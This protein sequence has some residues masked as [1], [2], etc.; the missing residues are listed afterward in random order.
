MYD[1]LVKPSRPIVNY[2]TKFSGITKEILQDVTTTLED[3]QKAMQNILPEDAILVGHSLNC[4]LEAMQ[5]S[6][7]SKLNYWLVG[8]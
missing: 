5:V 7:T 8:V 6:S 3:V 4:D 2:L 1:T